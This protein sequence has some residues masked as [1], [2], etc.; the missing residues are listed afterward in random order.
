MKYDTDTENDVM[1]ND[2]STVSSP[3]KPVCLSRNASM[4]G[5]ANGMPVSSVVR[6]ENSTE[7]CDLGSQEKDFDTIPTSSFHERKFSFSSCS[8]D[9]LV[10]SKESSKQLS[11]IHNRDKCNEA[12][13][14]VSGETSPEAAPKSPKS[15][16]PNVEDHDDRAKPPLVQ[17]RGRFKVT[18]GRLDLDKV[19]ATISTLSIFG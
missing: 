11:N 15:A 19:L 8:S 3:E 17:Q 2:K 16:A 9:G 1:V 12:P 4:L 6:K 18:P 5:T 10:S 13:L 14:H 7:S